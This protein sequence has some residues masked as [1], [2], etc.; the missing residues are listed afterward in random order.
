MF[1]LVT[2]ALVC[3]LTLTSC[4]DPDPSLAGC[5]GLVVGGGR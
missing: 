5:G 2:L 1:R 3:I 4:G